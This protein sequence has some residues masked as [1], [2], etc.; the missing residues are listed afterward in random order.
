MFVISTAIFLHSNFSAVANMPIFVKNR[1]MKK[2][3][4]RRTPINGIFLCTK[5]MMDKVAKQ[6]YK[7]M[8]QACLF[9]FPVI[10]LQGR[11]KGAPPT[12]WDLNYQKSKTIF[13]LHKFNDEA[14]AGCPK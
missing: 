10:T 8:D 12:P 3:N 9:T 7:Y 11:I 1:N 2:Y 13:H 6:T 4:F 14:R 5:M